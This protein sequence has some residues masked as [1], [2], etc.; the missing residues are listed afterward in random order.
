L[1]FPSLISLYKYLKGTPLLVRHGPYSQTSNQFER[2]TRRT[3]SLGYFASLLSFVF[4]PG[5]P[6]Q[7]SLMFVDKARQPTLEWIA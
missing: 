2:L 6:I 7:P 5:R 1:S 3:N 4:V